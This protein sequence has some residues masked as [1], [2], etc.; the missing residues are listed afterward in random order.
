MGASVDHRQPDGLWVTGRAGVEEVSPNEQR[1][2]L[3]V[4]LQRCNDGTWGTLRQAEPLI[5]RSRAASY[6]RRQAERD[7]NREP[8][9]LPNDIVDPAGFIPR[10]SVATEQCDSPVRECSAM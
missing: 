8:L 4:G 7:H 3:A 10:R 1:S 5:G 2:C 6:D 9:H